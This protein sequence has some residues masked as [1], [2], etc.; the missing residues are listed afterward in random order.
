MSSL[1]IIFKNDTNVY[2]YPLELLISTIPYIK[3][4]YETFKDAIHDTP[5]EFSK[6][7]KE[8]FDAILANKPLNVTKPITD[9][10][11]KLQYR[12][13]TAKLIKLRQVMSILLVNDDL[14]DDAVFEAL[15]LFIQEGDKSRGGVV[16]DLETAKEIEEYN[17]QHLIYN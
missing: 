13:N 12:E 2:E 16:Y 14:H 17:K 3:D 1:K 5:I 10:A 9:P 8:Y 7:E 6:F 15:T 11:N 4:L